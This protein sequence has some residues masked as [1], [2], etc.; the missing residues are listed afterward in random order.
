[1]PKKEN[2]DRR[3]ALVLDWRDYGAMIVAMLETTLLPIVI[4]AIVLLLLLVI[5]K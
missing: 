2:E 5:I 4:A 1:M 3:D